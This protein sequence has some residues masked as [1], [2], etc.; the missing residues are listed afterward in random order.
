[1]HLLTDW[2]NLVSGWLVTGLDTSGNRIAEAYR[3]REDA[4][5]AFDSIASGTLWS[6]LVTGKRKVEY[7][8]RS[9]RPI[10]ALSVR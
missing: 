1:M 5:H 9:R 6:V 2:R 10:F 7:R 8:K 3:Y 4:M